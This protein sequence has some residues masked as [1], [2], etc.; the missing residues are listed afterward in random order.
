MLKLFWLRAGTMISRIKQHYF[1]NTYLYT[2]IATV[3]LLIMVFSAWYTM[4]Q[5]AQSFDNRLHHL[6]DLQINSLQQLIYDAERQAIMASQLVAS[7]QQI[8][9]QLL[10]ASGYYQQQAAATDL[11]ILRQQVLPLLDHYWQALIPYGVSQLH[12]HLAPD[13]Y[14]FLRAHRSQHYGDRVA[15]VRPMLMH[16]L[17]T[18]QNV[19]GIELGRHGLGLRAVTPVNNAQ[20]KVQAAVEVG[21]DLQ[22]IFQQQ[23]DFINQGDANNA[24]PITMEIL[25]KADLTTAMNAD[26]R[27]PWFGNQHWSTPQPSSALQ[28]WLANDM[29][30]QQLNTATQLQ[31]HHNGNQ[32]LVSVLPLNIWGQ[33]SEQASQLLS[34]S[35]QNI[36]PQILKQQSANQVIWTIWLLASVALLFL[37]LLLV[38]YL[39]REAQQEV[40]EQQA[41]LR[42]SEQKLLALYQ[43]SP[44]PILLN[45]F[46]DGAYIDANPAMEQLAGYTPQELKQLSYWDLTPEYYS[47]AEQQQLKALTETGRYG[48]YIKQYRHKNGELI[49]IELN[50]VLFSDAQDE[51]F[52]WSI[53]KDIREIKRIEKLKDDFVSTVSHELRTP[54]T[55]ISGSLGLVLGGAGGALSPKVEK[56]L[57]I[58]HKNS[59]RLN[60]LINDLLDIEK[61]MAGKMRFDEAAVALPRLLFEALE[62]HQPFAQQHSVRL[63]LNTVPDVQLWLDAARIQ[64]VLA[65]FLS[66]AVKFSPPHF[67]VVLGAEVH[68]QKVKIWVRDQGVGIAMADQPQLFK[69]FSQLNHK[70]HQPK[71]G[72]G[73]GL[74]ISR[75]IAVQS[76][77]NV[78]VN[79]TVGEGAT[80]W[81]ELP[82]YQ[83]SIQPER[84]ETIL[85]VEDDADTAVVLCE[86]L[87]ALNYATD[88]APDSVTAW[89]R[90]AEQRYDA[91]TLDLKLREENGADFFLRLR[92]N[93]ATANVPVLIISA[94]VEQGKLQLA[95]L[96]NALDWLEKPVTPELLSLK[97]GQL[98]SQLQGEKRYQRILHIEDDSDIVTI[99][100]LQLDR[101]CDYQ[102]VTSLA[103][104]GKI[105]Q[106]QRFDLILLDLGLPDGNGMSLLNAITQSQGDIPVVIFS[107]QDL[108][109]ENKQ[110]V[111]AVFSKSR[112]N[113]EILAK[114]LKNILN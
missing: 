57:G 18:G 76:G 48:P 44:L 12:L 94:F 78:G 81:L 20:G 63:V 69:R 102:A 36:T 70:D 4:L 8:K 111:R 108:S 17:N 26:I 103:Q 67:E 61:L 55:S 96:A 24:E 79:S 38:S 7:D 59:Q 74:A 47:A 64:Q 46:S 27:Q 42:Q 29:L 49:D 113:T 85:V 105:L 91:I 51:K 52:I 32:Y 90:L 33:T 19:S 72:T 66:N 41:L 97:L 112:I 80:F 34:L 86:F 28:H 23:T 89:Q 13:A 100:R 95:A 54:L 65:N 60:L 5:R 22:Q 45:R 92:D 71:G 50:G 35:W 15:D 84:Y 82:L 101:Q 87:Q 73:L 104:A 56:L 3:V 98:L 40:A 106:Q 88:W 6:Y 93:P 99:M 11:T 58:A 14:T 75:E 10:Q 107:A 9:Q 83:A 43:L 16:S 1:S 62:Q 68:E 114:Y 2:L 21:V 30:P 37:G 39:R 110:K 31:L 25:V 53:I 77:G 109:V